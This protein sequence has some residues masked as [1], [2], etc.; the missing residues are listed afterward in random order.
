MDTLQPPF[1]G[2]QPPTSFIPKKSLV[3]K[4][5]Y[6][7]SYGIFTPIAVILL[8]LSAGLYGGAYAYDYQL[9]EQAKADQET[10]DKQEKAFD[11]KLLTDLQKLDTRI[12]ITKQLLKKHVTLLP[13]LDLLASETIRG[14]RLTSLAYTLAPG[15]GQTQVHFSGE[16]RDY[17]AIALQSDVFGADNAIIKNFLFGDLSLGKNG[18]VDFSLDMG[19]EPSIFSY[20]DSLNKSQ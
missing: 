12:A 1:S 13:L 17:D 7:R 19:L 8:V 16:S 6:K 10:I 14:L 3:V 9:Q 20:E 5:E 11:T 18:S 4:P 15:S 2:Q